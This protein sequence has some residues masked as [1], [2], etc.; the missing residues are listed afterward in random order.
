MKVLPMEDFPLTLEQ[1][2]K[3]QRIYLHK[4]DSNLKLDK[5][6]FTFPENW[7]DEEMF[8]PRQFGLLD[9]PGVLRLDFDDY[10]DSVFGDV[11]DSIPDSMDQEIL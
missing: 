8:D 11:V 7:R 9:D 6:K 1:F 4:S 3:L 5:I 2:I 10:S